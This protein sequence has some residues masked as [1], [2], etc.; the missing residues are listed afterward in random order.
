MFITPTGL[1]IRITLLLLLASLPGN[2]Q[3]ATDPILGTIGNLLSTNL[4]GPVASYE[5]ERVGYEPTGGQWAEVGRHVEEFGQFDERGRLI[6]KR[7]RPIKGGTEGVDKFVYDERGNITR[8]STASDLNYTIRTETICRVDS[9]TFRRTIQDRE[10]KAALHELH[11][12]LPYV[13]F[14]Y[15]LGGHNGRIVEK[16][17][18]DKY[19][20]GLRVR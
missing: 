17:F 19:L 10:G 18:I 12:L 5:V 13:G 14:A 15:V 6:E 16:V 7:S 11:E 8:I 9:R 20:S 3:T 4:N 1:S 2:T